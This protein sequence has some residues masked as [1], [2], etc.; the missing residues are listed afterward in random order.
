MWQQW[1]YILRYREKET[2]NVIATELVLQVEENQQT[3]KPR[4]FSG[5]YK[6]LAEN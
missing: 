3:K 6:Y 2:E 5:S 1:I 4:R